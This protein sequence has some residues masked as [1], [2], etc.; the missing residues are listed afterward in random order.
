[1][2]DGINITFNL[3]LCYLFD[4]LILQ[5][6]EQIWAIHREIY[7]LIFGFMYKH[8]MKWSY[9]EILFTELNS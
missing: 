2:A 1:M 9:F 5:L 3:F 6:C 7:V 4:H 8:G